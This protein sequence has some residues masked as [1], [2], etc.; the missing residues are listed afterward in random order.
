M[1]GVRDGVKCRQ[2]ETG[3]TRPDESDDSLL[4]SYAEYRS[5]VVP[6]LNTLNGQVLHLSRNE[7][8]ITQLGKVIDHI[9]V[10]D[11]V[12]KKLHRRLKS[13]VHPVRTRIE[14]IMARSGSGARMLAAA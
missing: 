7:P 3:V 2:T 4:T 14:Q 12:K 1:D 9:I 11:G 8:L 6:G 10:P 5:K 13:P